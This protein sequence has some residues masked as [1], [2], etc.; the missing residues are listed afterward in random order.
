MGAILFNEG[1]ADLDRAGV[2]LGTLGSPAD[3][4]AI[5]AS[6][7][8]GADLAKRLAAGEAIR[9]ALST[10]TISEERETFNVLAQTDTG[11]TDRVVMVGAHLDSVADG[12]GINDNGTGTAAIL[13][14]AQQLANVETTNAVRFAFFGAEEAGLLGAEH[15]VADLTARERK[16]IALNL[17]FD[18]LGSPNFARFIYDGDGSATGTSGPNGSGNIEDVFTEYFASQGLY[19][20]ETA[21]DGRSDYGPFIAAGIPAGGL[22]S[23]AEGIKTEAQAAPD[24][25]GGQANVAYDVCYHSACDDIT[26]VNETGLDQLADAAAHAVLTF[27]QTTSSVNGTARASGSDSGATAEHKGH[28]FKR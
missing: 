4:P 21:F 14:I 24:K 22:F 9:V 12:A 23:G 7:E 16:D 3:I 19:T 28:A 2:L 15:Y 10:D 20:E 18:M 11:R 5:G 27:A 8:V 13:E 17:N 26:N 1:Q 6:Y 25:F